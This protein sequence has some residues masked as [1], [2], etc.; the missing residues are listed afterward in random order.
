MPQPSSVSLIFYNE[1]KEGLEGVGGLDE[2]LPAFLH[3]TEQLIDI[4]SA[5]I[6]R[7]SENNSRESSWFFALTLE[8]E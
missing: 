1:I 2:V 6:A 3:N 7:I 4:F 8:Y 5:A